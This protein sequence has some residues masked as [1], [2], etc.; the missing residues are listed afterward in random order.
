MN[1][2][3]LEQGAGN[4]Q[5]VVLFHGYGADMHDLFG[6]A[7]AIPGSENF[8]WVF[9]NGIQQVEIG[10]HMYGRAW[11]PINMAEFEKA[12]REGTT[13]NLAKKRPA[14]LDKAIEAAEKFIGELNVASENL[15]LGG[16]SQGAM[17]AVEVLARR[18]ENVRGAIFLS[19]NLMDEN[20]LKPLVANHKGQKFYQ[21]H[22]THDP[23]LSFDGAKNLE[24]LLTKNEWVGHLDAFRGGHEIPLN[25]I[26]NIGHFIARL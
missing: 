14:G 13:R 21:T 9:P 4:P 3:F 11:Y 17:L 8:R 24:D 2:E 25:V 1:L 12:M 6:L 19:G 26:Q 16:F 22:G 20:T 5:T 18:K 10:P 15:I 7:S 23:I